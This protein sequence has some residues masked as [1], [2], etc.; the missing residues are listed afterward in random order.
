M[1]HVD[2]FRGDVRN[3]SVFGSRH[4]KT[5]RAR[6][7]MVEQLVPER[8]DVQNSRI[9]TAEHLD[10]VGALQLQRLYGICYFNEDIE[11]Q[12]CDDLGVLLP[13]NTP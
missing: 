10:V 7:D 12:N 11:R 2:V 8:G 1:G 9:S 4:Q 3:F 5:R 13:L 6:Q